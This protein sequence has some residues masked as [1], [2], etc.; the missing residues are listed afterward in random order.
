MKP[1]G[2]E[3]R[4]T[5]RPVRFFFLLLFFFFWSL[6]VAADPLPVWIEADSWQVRAIYRQPD[7]SWSPPV[8]WYFTVVA[9][10][11]T[12]AHIEVHGG[13]S[14]R[15][16]LTF[17]RPGGQLRRIGLIDMIRDEEVYREI[18][19]EG[20]APVY[21]LL[22]AI[23]YHFPLHPIEAGQGPF[24]LQRYLNARKL[25]AEELTQS[26]R[27]FSA[28]ELPDLAP[29]QAAADLEALGA[30]GTVRAF[31]I[32]KSG[33]EVF[34]QYWNTQLPWALYTESPSC[35]AWLAR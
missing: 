30:R 5:C 24:V 33:G 10:D 13:G 35:K 11:E 4:Q 1:L 25:P 34:T 17:E 15:A 19:I 3:T 9:A 20:H 16:Q 22:S 23:P 32:E 2:A 28:M 8:T 6:P 29:G 27:T 21:P 14:S 18:R 12:R 31:R 26:V 7:G